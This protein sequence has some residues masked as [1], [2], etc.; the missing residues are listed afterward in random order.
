[1]PK[2]SAKKKLR[3]AQHQRTRPGRTRPMRPQPEDSAARYH[4]SGKLTGKVVFISGGDSGIGRA[5]AVAAAKEGADVALLYREGT[6]DA[7]VTLALITATGQ[8]ALAIAGD[9]GRPATCTRAVKHVV[10]AWGRLDVVINNAAEQHPQENIGDITPQQLERTF[11]TN[12]FGSFYLT[13]AA[14]P[15]LK[16]GASIII[17]TSIT[18]YRGSPKLLDYSATKGALCALTRSLAL[19]LVGKGIRVNAVAPGPVW[20]PLI[21][22]TFPAQAVATFGS[23]VPMKRAGQPD[24][25]APAFIYLACAD[26]SYV[27]GQTLHVNGG[28]IING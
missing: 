6:E 7:N 12:V 8:R 15:H 10:R 14:L 3:P 27:T 24:E 13:Q 18:A 23:T 21:P 9:V 5:V 17:T 25:L 2:T 20:T 26:S 11:R 1:M 4:G 22:S 19:A 16:K 28:E